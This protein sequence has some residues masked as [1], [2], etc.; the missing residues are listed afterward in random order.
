MKARFSYFEAG[1]QYGLFV[2]RANKKE[3][4]RQLFAQI[5]DEASHLNSQEKSYNRAWMHKQKMNCEKR[6]FKL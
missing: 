3:E 6:N 4:A 2:I 1:Y 5:V